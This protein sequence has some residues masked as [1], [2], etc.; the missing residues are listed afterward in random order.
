[1]DKNPLVLLEMVERLGNLMRAEFRRIGGDEQLHPVHIHA[2]LY[3]SK[4]NRFS[5]SPQALADYLGI[6]MVPRHKACFYW[7]AAA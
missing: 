4:A 7:T 1:M 2:L 6:T 5:N 3:L